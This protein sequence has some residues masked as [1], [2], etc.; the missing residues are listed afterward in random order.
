MPA[1][2]QYT[3]AQLA[4]LETAR[5]ARPDGHLLDLLPVP[6]DLMTHLPTRW[7]AQ[8]HDAF[9]MEIRYRHDPRQVTSKRPSSP[10]RSAPSP[11]SFA[12]ATTCPRPGRRVFGFKG[13]LGC[14]PNPAYLAR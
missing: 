14:I 13:T 2:T 6:G 12:S 4:Q 3:G 10:P 8:L 11:R 7:H 5:Q 9:G 1:A